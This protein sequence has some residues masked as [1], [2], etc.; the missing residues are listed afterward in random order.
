MWYPFAGDRRLMSVR[1][2]RRI[3]PERS[4]HEALA[5]RAFANYG[6]RWGESLWLRPERVA[7]LVAATQTEGFQHLIDATEMGRGVIL[8]LPHQGNFELAAPVTASLGLQVVA[9]AENLE[10][11][12]LRDWFTR[13]RESFDIRIVY[14]DDPAVIRGLISEMDAETAIALVSDRDLTRRGIEVEFFGE[15]TTLPSGPAAL[16]LRTGAPIVPCATYFTPGA[17]LLFVTPAI[18]IPADG[19]VAERTI[20]MTQELARRLEDLIRRDPGQWL[21]L[22]PNW[23]SDH[24]PA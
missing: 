1:H 14:A 19:S 20:V 24:V 15:R 17:N 18:E 6:R 10:N 23:P 7:G 3:A 22:Q 5:R 12:L 4:D 9:V 21:V 16:S 8:A 2:M 13:L 11:T